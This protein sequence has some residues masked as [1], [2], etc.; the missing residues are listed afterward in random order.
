MRSVV[1]DR[2]VWSV[3]LS[4]GPSVTL[5]SPVKTAKPIDMPFRLRTRVV[6]GNHVL[7]GGPDLP[8][9]RGN[10]EEEGRPIVHC[11]R[12][13]KN[14]WTDRF[15]FRLWTRVGRRKNKFSCIR[16]VTPIC[17]QYH[18]AVHVRRRCGLLSNYF[19]HLLHSAYSASSVYRASEIR[20]ADVKSD[21]GFLS[22]C[23]SV[24]LSRPGNVL[25]RLT[26]SR[27]LGN[28]SPRKERISLENLY[29]IRRVKWKQVATSQDSA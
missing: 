10:V 29:L 4:V 7:D 22:V 14:G 3:D 6:P 24:C 19:D 15:A 26:E 17:F 8:M 11:G 23:L 9:G 13:C 28:F 1:T 25:K 2:V 21:V 20:V 27:D 18:W 5:M 16:Q 12:L